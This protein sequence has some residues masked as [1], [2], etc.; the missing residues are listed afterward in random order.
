MATRLCPELP[1]KKFFVIPDHWKE[2]W[3]CTLQGNYVSLTASEKSLGAKPKNCNKIGHE[4]KPQFAMH[5]E[6]LNIWT[7][8][9]IY[10]SANLASSFKLSDMMTE[11]LSGPLCI[12]VMVDYITDIQLR[13]EGQTIL[14][15]L[16]VSLQ[17]LEMRAVLPTLAGPAVTRV[18]AGP[19]LG[20]GTWHPLYIDIRVNITSLKSLQA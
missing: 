8:A 13:E 16:K 14:A 10:S 20:P 9:K 6:N 2:W 18:T 19:W 17:N 4:W 1:T 12:M 3:R 15:S 5:F 11:K 7:P